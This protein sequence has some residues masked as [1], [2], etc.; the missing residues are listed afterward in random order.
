[1]N[2][3]FL[4][5]N[6][7][8]A[9]TT[10]PGDGIRALATFNLG[11]DIAVTAFNPATK[12]AVLA[13]ETNNEIL[14]NILKSLLSPHATNPYPILQI[15]IVGG[16]DNVACREKLAMI[17]EIIQRVD[18]DRHLINIASCAANEKP[19][20]QSFKLTSFDGNIGVLD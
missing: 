3:S 8:E 10:S 2:M 15:R 1:M 11:K 7:G 13:R 20:P 6:A 19:H 14:E 5:V 17:V 4:I 16:Q 9:K 18:S 12:A